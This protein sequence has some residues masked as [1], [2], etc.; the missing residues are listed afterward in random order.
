MKG[1]K[2][3]PTKLKILHGNPGK[4][5]LPKNEPEP[6]PGTLVPPDWLKGEGLILW[7]ELVPVLDEMGVLSTSDRFALAALCSAYDDYREAATIVEREGQVYTRT[8]AAG[9]TS[10]AARPEI[11]IRNDAFRRMASMLGEF[12]LTPSSRTRVSAN[13]KKPRGKLQELL[14]RPS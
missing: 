1:R 8:T 3:K 11:A 4:R 6:L 2:M 7:G 13:P 9:S 5:K 14:D 10:V 12:G